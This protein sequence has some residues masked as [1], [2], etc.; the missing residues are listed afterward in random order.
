MEAGFYRY[1]VP[2]VFKKQKTHE[3]TIKIAVATCFRGDFR[4][5]SISQPVACSKPQNCL[6]CP[7]RQTLLFIN[8]SEKNCC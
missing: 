7:L 5:S 1:L 3:K 6:P 2:T 8:K 4:R